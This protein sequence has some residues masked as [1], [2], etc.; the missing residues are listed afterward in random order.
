MLAT[1]VPVN[2]IYA[3]SNSI[4]SDAEVI[5]QYGDSS[6]DPMGITRE[7][8]NPTDSF[9]V[10]ESE[11]KVFVTWVILN[12]NIGSAS[13]Y[14]SIA[15][16]GKWI[17]TDKLVSS[18]N[19]SSED[20]KDKT[21]AYSV[22][23]GK[24]IYVG[25]TTPKKQQFILEKI[26]LN[27]NGDIASNKMI[28][29][30]DM[31]TND[32]MPYLMA[33]ETSHGSGFF[34]EEFR[35]GHEKFDLKKERTFVILVADTNEIIRFHPSERSIS[36]I[37]SFSLIPDYVDIEN[38]KFYYNYYYQKEIYAYDYKVDEPVYDENGIA[39][40]ISNKAFPMIFPAHDG[41]FYV[42]SGHNDSKDL[43]LYN[44]RLEPISNYITISNIF[45]ELTTTNDEI[46][47]W[48]KVDFKQK[49][50]LRLTKISKVK[51]TTKIN[52]ESIRYSD[53][54]VNV[55]ID[56]ALQTFEQP[57]VIMNEK[58]MVPMR[59]IFEAL[60]A[61]IKWD[62]S[63]QSVTATKGST[64]ILLQ[65]DSAVA[66]I[67]NKYVQLEQ[68][69]AIINGSSMV[70]VR[71]VSEALKAK[72]E[73]NN[74][75]RTISISTSTSVALSDNILQR[76]SHLVYANVDDF[77]GLTV[78]KFIDQVYQPTKANYSTMTVAKMSTLKKELQEINDNSIMPLDW[79]IIDYENDNGDITTIGHTGFYGAAFKNGN[80]IVIAF[81]GT[82]APNSND[83]DA[84]TLII[85]G[86]VPDQMVSARKLV[87]RVATSNP[88]SRILLTG[89]SLGGWLAQKMVLDIKQGAVKAPNFSKAVT[90]NAPGFYEPDLLVRLID[91]TYL[92]KQQWD[93]NKK[94]IYNNQVTNYVINDDTVGTVG[95]SH[96]GRT[97]T[98][99][100]S[101]QTHKYLLNLKTHSILNFYDYNLN[102]ING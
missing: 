99:N 27:G 39:K 80:D 101:Y 16:N 1:S 82:E 67:D 37:N 92:T 90:F 6:Y 86:I 40:F 45:F 46:H 38:Q 35:T 10:A 43:M 34:Y 78:K 95:L 100:T 41:N 65:I 8:G 97:L 57:P 73:W 87:S 42:L 18:W 2:S 96:I 14:T 5:K 85:R 28:L 25:Y 22:V 83:I 54:S 51:P 24:H 19:L 58:T 21:Y 44:N 11:N 102:E 70:P 23:S 76:F 15:E 66:K 63:T 52:V 61:T 62:G 94:G 81:R 53:A 60:G 9:G 26:T 91:N 7:E 79:S 29:S 59:K 74:D 4:L 50:A 72:V 56:G 33:V 98:L 77:V 31:R 93:D 47:L 17:I 32:E 68:A 75:T 49:P 12:K 89:H 20:K 64:S 88:A 3:E 71:F 30:N 36:S 69:P 48:E 55:K 84:D 13:L